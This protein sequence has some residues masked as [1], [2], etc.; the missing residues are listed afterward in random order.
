ML[1]ELRYLKKSKI[2]RRTSSPTHCKAEIVS[3]W[4][5]GTAVKCA[6]YYF[7][8]ELYIQPFKTQF[9][10]LLTLR[11]GQVS[12]LVFQL[13]NKQHKNTVD[14]KKHVKCLEGSTILYYYGLVY[15]YLSIKSL[16]KP[17]F[18]QMF[19]ISG[20]R[21][22]RWAR[23]RL[24]LS[25]QSSHWVFVQLYSRFPFLFHQS[26]VSQAERKE[27][28]FNGHNEFFVAAN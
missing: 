23:Y 8:V 17:I 28:Y 20:K 16:S 10:V 5:G 24:F 21:D 22:Q 19:G 2:S 12:Q 18:G 27:N 15:F 7:K 11:H 14:I 1:L 3:V 26:K 4:Q 6:N 9:S 13:Q 25:N